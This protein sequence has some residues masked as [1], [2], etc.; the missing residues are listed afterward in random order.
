M[1]LLVVVEEDTDDHVPAPHARHTADDVAASE[2]E[3]VPATQEMHELE[4]AGDHLPPPHE[5]HAAT[6]VAPIVVE[7]IPAAHA[8]HP[9]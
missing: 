6:V 8:M 9:L 2:V 3:Y 1:Q 7:Y 5:V 4:A